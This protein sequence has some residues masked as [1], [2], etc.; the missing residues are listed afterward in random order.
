MSVSFPSGPP[1][2]ARPISGKSS[3]AA[4]GCEREV[5]CCR[6]AGLQGLILQQEADLQ[7][8]TGTIYQ[9][10]AAV[11]K[12]TRQSR[13]GPKSPLKMGIKTESMGTF[14]VHM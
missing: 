13:L 12:Q 14:L 7:P 8:W 4:L 3:S 5:C 11:T 10:S 6:R 2:P 1:P 9:H